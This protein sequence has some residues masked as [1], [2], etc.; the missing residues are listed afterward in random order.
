MN[1]IQ[2]VVRSTSLRWVGYAAALITAA[3]GLW[4][5]AANLGR[6]L[7]LDEAWVANSVL[8][9][10]L[11]DM[12]YYE[13][14]VQTTPPLFLLLT[15]YWVR[16]GGL[17]NEAL[18]AIPVVSSVLAGLIMFL[19]A[20]RLMSRWTALLAWTLLFLS[21]TAITWARYLKQYST[22]L[23]V[24]ALLLWLCVRY[25][26]QPAVRRFALL[27]GAAL[28][29]LLASYPTA[30]LLPGIALALA[31]RSLVR[32]AQLAVGGS[33]V[34]AAVHFLFVRPNQS[35]DLEAFFFPRDDARG[36]MERVANNA[37]LYLAHLPVPSRVL[38]AEWVT[39]LAAVAFIGVGFL[40]AVRRF[41]RGRRLW[42]EA[43]VICLSPCAVMLVCDALGLYPVTQRTT[44]FATPALVLVFAMSLDL[45]HGPLRLRLGGG[46][47][48]P[49]SR[50]GVIGLIAVACLSA[51]GRLPADE[52]RLPNEEVAAA[53]EF[54]QRHV[55]PKDVVWVHASSSESFRLYQRMLGWQDAPARFGQTGWPCCPRGVESQRGMG[56]PEKVRADVDAQLPAGIAQTVWILN[57]T[58]AAHWRFV[59]VD[60]AA[61]F[62]AVLRQRGCR[63]QPG[64]R[65][66]NIAVGRF[67][68]A[69][70]D[71][72]T[73]ARDERH[74]LSRGK[75]VEIGVQTGYSQVDP[76]LGEDR[77]ADRAHRALAIGI[78]RRRVAKP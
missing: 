53:V 32:A 76:I 21:P 22:E 12:F 3:C 67:H 11:G 23:L 30:L 41:R 40:L 47:H 1:F 73:S 2:R 35:R 6:S 78:K 63:E 16:W 31:G 18:R 62:G 20:R 5:R 60:E 33:A 27:A 50:F 77:V 7:W 9:T 74:R 13:R 19:L 70:I 65:F 46:W 43:Y 37:L 29:G 64:P 24:T 71:A 57:T 61:E 72:P 8:A 14:W 45:L 28:V 44:L 55:G 26:E 69:G 59:G 15:R 54:L 51:L 36:L 34:A 48:R 66:H 56:S 4:L 68:C 42:L 75:A 38:L 17:S 58:R 52:I 49:L 10:T 25:L 39:G